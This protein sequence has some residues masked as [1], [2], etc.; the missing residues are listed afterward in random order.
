MN[1][2]VWVAVK[3][4]WRVCIAKHSN[5]SISKDPRS[6]EHM[7]VR[8]G[9]TYICD[10]ID[11]LTKDSEKYFVTITDDFSRFCEVHF[12]KCKSDILEFKL[13]IKLNLY[14]I[15]SDELACH[16]KKSGVVIDPAPPIHLLWM[17]LLNE[18]T[19]IF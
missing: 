18:L 9:P 13:F 15:Q 11:S 17:V 16:C 3:P 12:L 7:P 4:L 2:I 10:H 19:D 14:K 8:M 1:L 5:T 6:R